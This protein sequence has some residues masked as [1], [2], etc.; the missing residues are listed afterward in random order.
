MIEPQFTWNAIVVVSIENH[1]NQS[2][3]T[4]Q[5]MFE[6][7]REHAKRNTELQNKNLL[8][9]FFD[10]NLGDTRLGSGTK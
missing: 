8:N 9:V 2:K 6:A 5:D 10:V 4:F 3:V 1:K 7:F